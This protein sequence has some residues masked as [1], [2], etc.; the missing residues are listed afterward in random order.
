[1]AMSDPAVQLGCGR[2]MDDVWDHIETPPDQ[3]ELT[4]PFC[5]AARA[6]LAALARATRQLRH[7]EIN[8]DSL[9]TSP[10]T[11]DRILTIARTEVRRGRRLPLT[12]PGPARSSDLTVSEQAV[13]TVIR[14]AGDRL[15]DVQIRRCAVELTPA[16]GAAASP[17]TPGAEV[18]AAARRATSTTLSPGRVR[19]GVSLRVSVGSA[20][21]IPETMDALRRTISASVDHEVGVVVD[22]I[23]VTVEDVHD[24]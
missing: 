9:Q 10:A 13:A 6:D 19:I 3:H 11:L 23:D 8:D 1:M 21:A 24:A 17:S 7:D 16:D 5:R 14:R 2:S 18:E 15:P 12:P 22:R 4:C 20:T